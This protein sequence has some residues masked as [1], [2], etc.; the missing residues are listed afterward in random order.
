MGHV[1]DLTEFFPTYREIKISILLVEGSKL[2]ELTLIT[3]HMA[4]GFKNPALV[5][6][7]KNRER[8][9]IWSHRDEPLA[10]L[11]YFSAS[12]E[13][14]PPPSYPTPPSPLPGILLLTGTMVRGAG[15]STFKELSLQG[16]SQPFPQGIFVSNIQ[17]PALR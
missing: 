5:N 7:K 12:S 1:Y 2:N 8:E 4:K 13:L 16:R 10:I 3:S 15:E 9:R 14:H 6:L 17:L 11:P